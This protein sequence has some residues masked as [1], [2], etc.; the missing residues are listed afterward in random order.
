MLLWIQHLTM[1]LNKLK[2]HTELLKYGKCVPECLK[3][4]KNKKN[5]E[6]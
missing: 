4:K 1:G 3:N 2:F 6:N 5:K